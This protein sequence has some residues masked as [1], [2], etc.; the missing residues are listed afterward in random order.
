MYRHFRY[1][2]EFVYGGVDGVITTFAIVMAGVGAG[3]SAS[4]I[5]VIGFAN[6]FADAFSMA[7]SS[8]LSAESEEAAI[9][10][11]RIERPLRRAFATF[12]SF[13]SVGAVPLAPF[14]VALMFPT[15]SE[16]VVALSIGATIFALVAVGYVSGVAEGKNPL[17]VVF[18]T[19]LIGGTAATIAFFVG[20]FLGGMVV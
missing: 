19:V 16:F 5:L 3:F 8:Y 14:V 6:V 2:P 18:R 15:L 11:G 10:G 4:I 1:L 9:S 13:S 12:F 20:V 7:S 17:I